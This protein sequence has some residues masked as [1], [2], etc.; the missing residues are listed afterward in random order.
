M[1]VPEDAFWS[2][3]FTFHSKRR[4]PPQPLLGGSR[5]SDL[6]M[7]VILPWLWVRASA[8][9]N[10]E[11]QRRAEERFAAWPKT[12]DNATLRLARRRLLGDL[13]GLSLKSAAHQQGLL[14]IVE[15]FC[16]HAN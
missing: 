10:R 13:P 6:A 3:H 2:W 14:Q 7:N 12:E 9:G 1:G 16:Q 5:A 15:D 4:D 11:G 8:A